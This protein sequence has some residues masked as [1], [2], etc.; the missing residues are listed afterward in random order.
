MVCSFCLQGQGGAGLGRL[1]KELEKICS[2]HPRA[3]AKKSDKRNF[4][5]IL[6]ERD[7]YKAIA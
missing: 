4:K 1:G 7:V 6:K 3:Q 5:A 2:E